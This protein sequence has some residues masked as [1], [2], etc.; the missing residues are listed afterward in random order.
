LQPLWR[1]PSGRR[2]PFGAAAGKRR[3]SIAIMIS[4]IVIAALA[5]WAS[6]W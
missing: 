6:A 4:G 3:R 1:Q 5:L 2:A